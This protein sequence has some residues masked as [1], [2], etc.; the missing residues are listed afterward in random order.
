[1]RPC[2]TRHFARSVVAAL[3]VLAVAPL[4]AQQGER[5]PL[6]VAPTSAGIALR[7]AWPEGA[8]PLGWHLERRESGGAWVRI[9]TTPIA[10]IRDRA[11]ARAVLGA[12]APR[13]E[14]YLFPENPLTA[15]RDAETRSSLLLLGADLDP[16][17]ALV[18][19]LRHDD[20]SVRTGA[21]YEYRLVAVRAS[22]ERI[23]AT[24]PSVMAGSFVPAPA[25][26]PFV[27][28]QVTAGVDLRWTPD[29]RYSAYHVYRSV[30]D[31]PAARLNEGPIVVFA[32]D[33]A[34]G[35]GVEG[36]HY[37]DLVAPASG[38]VR[39]AVEGV[40]AF[41]R[42]GTR[43]PLVAVTMRDLTAPL[44]PPM[45]RAVVRGDMVEVRWEPSTSPDVASYQLWR[46][47]GRDSTRQAVGT[48]V[49]A[50]ARTGV[51]AGRPAAQVQYYH[52]TARDRAG[53][54]SARS[55]RAIAEVPDLAA[56]PVP[57]GL[58]GAA[59]TGLAS[60]R[61]TA[62]TARDLRG[63]R[64]YRSSDTTRQ[65][66]LLTDRPITA[67]TF[68]D[69]L[70]ARADH[71][72]HYRITAVDSAWNES[73]PSGV[74][75]LSPPDSTAPTAPRIMHVRPSEERVVVQWL[76]NPEPD[77]IAYRVFWRERGAAEWRVA[78]DRVP[79]PATV[80]TIAGVTPRRLVEIS[81]QAL[82]DAGNASPLARPV[83]GESYH[84]RAPAVLEVRSAAFEPRERGVVLGWRSDAEPS[85]RVIVLRRLVGDSVSVRIATVPAAQRRFVDATAAAGKSYDYSL[86]ATDAFGNLAA[87]GRARRAGVPTVAGTPR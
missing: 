14:D 73:A 62:S 46:T 85:A 30:G 5:V 22:G 33:D 35:R 32:A 43:T 17:L 29:A 16:A 23:V 26:T 37:R 60:L 55:I 84:R 54:E 4:D 80:D 45:I 57:T 70:R 18:L 87:P 1:M 51:D 36:S 64:V 68:A 79:A 12:A 83:V 75:M 21:S 56:P 31:V 2:A 42:V 24:S 50:E 19:G 13:W 67:T 6:L 78:S 74:L 61:W 15:L 53:N 8:R 28:R 38:T 63:Y 9:T 66:G 20:G 52:V 49:S 71:A 81:V 34:V 25:P 7:W 44:P 11:R 41:G 47:I 59:V 72:F 39:Y 40:D 86:V 76:P 58:T 69:T 65:F 3:A 10:P 77:V 27:A 82:D 48:A